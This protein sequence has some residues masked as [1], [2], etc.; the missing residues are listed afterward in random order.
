MAGIYIHVPFCKKICSYCDFY[1]TAVTAR[2]PDYLKTLGKELEIRETYLGDALIETIYLGGGTPSLLSTTA[3]KQLL[4]CIMDRY[5]ISPDC[6][7][8]LEANP[9]DLSE[10]YLTALRNETP[11]NRISI[12]IQSFE[13]TDLQLLGRRHDA[14]QA[15]RSLEHTLK[16][17]FTNIS[18]DLI[19]GLPGMDLVQWQKNLVRAFSF[20]I[21]HLSAYHLSI[22]SRTAFSRLHARGLLTLPDEDES[23]RQFALLHDMAGQKGFIHYEISNLARP[24]CLSRHNTNYWQQKQYLGIGP[25]AHSYDIDSRQWNIADVGKYMEA[26]RHQAVFF[27]REEL[28]AVKRYNEYLMV[29][30][31]TLQ[32]VELDFLRQTF[33]HAAYQNFL[34]AIRK[35][36]ITGHV[37]EEG[38]I[39]RLTTAGWMISDYIITQLMA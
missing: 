2:I 15:I 14:V 4:R 20:D 31:R 25:S 11:V 16:A 37:T 8:T 21:A 27:E 38:P 23:S 28:D 1:K 6:E 30:L 35:F 17:G 22:E 18:M 7:V 24:G 12:G 10:E 9:D 39:C 29:S 33:G 3:L 5:R 34:N 26:I 32:G 36:K 19:Y 13:D